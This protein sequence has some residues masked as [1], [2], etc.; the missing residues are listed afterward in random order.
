M[1]RTGMLRKRRWA[2][3]RVLLLGM[4]NVLMGDDGLGVH[5]L[6]AL[7]GRDLSGA[8]R[9]EL[10][11]SLSDCFSVLEGYEHIVALDAVAAGEKPGSLYWL[12]REC[13]ARARSGRLTLHDD[14]L[15]DALD[16]AALRGFRPTLHVAGMEPLCW[17]RWSLEL[18]AP[19]RAAMPGYLDM[20]CRRLGELGTQTV[21]SGRC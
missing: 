12:P 9:L 8:D 13:F 21:P 17:Q 20:I 2:V 16:L 5:A 11:T 14:D 18:S 3:A 7:E 4:G 10:G 6:R 15:L 1:M 19:V